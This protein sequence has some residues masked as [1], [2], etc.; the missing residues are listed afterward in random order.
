M[1]VYDF[2]HMAVARLLLRLHP[3]SNNGLE[4][5]Y[6]A[7]KGPWAKMGPWAQK[8]PWIQ[9]GPTWAP[10]EQALWGPWAHMGPPMAGP[11][12]LDPWRPNGASHGGSLWGLPMGPTRPQR[13]PERCVPRAGPIL[14]VYKAN[15][16]ES[17]IC[18]VISL[19]LRLATKPHVGSPGG[20][21]LG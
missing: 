21:L 11:C 2:I 18:F 12:G 14:N 5:M 8:G 3:N 17:A 19:I 15:K 4:N 9:K 13:A 20:M 1:N 7:I 10:Y 6:K 16:P